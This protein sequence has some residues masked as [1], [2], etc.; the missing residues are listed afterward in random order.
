MAGKKCGTE[1][2]HDNGENCKRERRGERATRR[3]RQWHAKNVFFHACVRRWQKS[4]LCASRRERE[5]Q[6]EGGIAVTERM[7]EAREG[8]RVS[9]SCHG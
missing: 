1:G 4:L 7:R 8:V 5:R 9:F 6:G 2:R 3:G